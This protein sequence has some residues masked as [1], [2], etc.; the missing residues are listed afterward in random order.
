VN[1]DAWN[2]LMRDFQR[3]QNEMTREPQRVRVGD[4][5]DNAAWA[6]AW[7]RM[8]VDPSQ[9]PVATPIPVPDPA[10]EQRRLRAL[11]ASWRE[12]ALAHRW[13]IFS[14]QWPL[15]AWAAIVG[16]E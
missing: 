11:A 2:R 6:E 3:A 12:I 14:L 1:N 4:A 15:V 13:D 5:D 16:R 7:R 10:L 9:Q 8:L